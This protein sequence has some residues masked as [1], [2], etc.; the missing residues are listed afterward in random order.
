MRNVI[1]AG[2]AV[3]AMLGACSQSRAQ[4]GGANVQRSY[5]VGQFQQIH[6]AGPYE[7]QV[8]T[9]G[10][11]SVSA[12]GPEGLIE[13][14]VVEVKGDRLLIHP[15]RERNNW[16]AGW[17]G[18]RGTAIIQVT[19]PAL[20]A[21]AIAGSGGIR[22]DQVRGDRFDGSIAG[23]GDLEVGD[24]D[25]QQLKLSIAGSG[26]VRART[27]QARSSRY[28]IAG[29]GDIDAR[30]IRAETAEVSIA[31]SGAVSVQATGTADVK[32][33]GSGDVNVSGGAKCNVSK[34]GSGSVNCS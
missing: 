17:R 5:Q 11:P 23:S 1:L 10:S 6:V 12:S 31:G 7:V 3:A 33:M 16:F 24:L 25:V 20:N 14:L 4:D 9:G 28:S 26:D 22:I 34:S 29:S 8:R 30:G 32:I 2:V 13:R 21:A 19:A 18:S 27:G 15:R